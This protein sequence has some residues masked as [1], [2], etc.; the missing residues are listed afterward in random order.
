MLFDDAAKAVLSDIRRQNALFERHF[1]ELRGDACRILLCD[2]GLYGSTQRLLVSA[3]PTLRIESVQFARANYKGHSE[4]HFKQVTGLMVERNRYSP[5]DVRSSVLRYWH[6]IESL[7]EP[8]VPSVTSFVDQGEEVA[9]NC[10]DIRFGFIDPSLGNELLS[11]ALS[12][13]DSLPI[14]GGAAALRDVE[15]AWTRLKRAITRPTA[16][17]L[18]CLEVPARSVDFGRPDMLQALPSDRPRSALSKLISLRFELWR[19]GAIAR[20]FPVLKHA[21][22]PMIDS[23]HS[24]RGIMARQ[25]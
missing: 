23:V 21:L 13:V 15:I 4:E 3:F 18:R 5:L 9:A 10:G 2:T 12:Y 25:H 7:F 24:V 1:A 20:Q 14:D 16:G 22:L 19:E 17:E 8:A 6:L 11:G